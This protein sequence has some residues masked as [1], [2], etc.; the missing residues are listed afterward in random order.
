VSVRSIFNKIVRLSCFKT[1]FEHCVLCG[2]KFFIQ[3]IFVQLNEHEAI[4]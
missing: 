4:E 1:Q 2:P 3:M